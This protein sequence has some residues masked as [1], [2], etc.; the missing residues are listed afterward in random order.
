M[1]IGAKHPDI[2]ILTVITQDWCPCKGTSGILQEETNQKGWQSIH[3]A[4]YISCFSSA[5]G[6]VINNRGC[7]K[8]SYFKHL[9]KK[10]SKTQKQQPQNPKQN[11]KKPNQKPTQ[12]KRVLC[13]FSNFKQWNPLDLSPNN[14]IKFKSFYTMILLSFR[15]LGLS[16]SA[17]N[18][19]FIPLTSTSTRHKGYTQ[20][21]GKNQ[22][23]CERNVSSEPLLLPWTDACPFFCTTNI[24][25]QKAD[26]AIFCTSQ[27]LQ[28]H[29][30]V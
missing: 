2:I 16:D 30:I 14:N 1:E 15:E 6:F 4:L 18:E 22:S 26:V 3:F 25:V 29:I 27:S 17:T 20:V 12:E 7:S 11:K 21:K 19:K 10:T 24:F 8:K 9:R 28:A 5:A 13:S 23:R